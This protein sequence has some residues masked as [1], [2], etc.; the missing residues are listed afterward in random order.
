MSEC[1][2]ILGPYRSGTSLTA[3]VLE[4]L[5]VDFGPREERIATNPYNPGGYLERGDLNAINRKLIASTGRTLGS[6]GDPECLTRLADRS[7]L[8]G[9]T[10]PWPGHATIWGLKD[11]RF[12][13]T[14]K[15]WLDSGALSADSIRIVQVTRD[16]ESIVLS[17]LEHPS[18]QK[19]CGRD[20]D[21][22]R[23]MVQEYVDL[24]NWQV[25]MLGVPTLQVQYEELIQ[26]PRAEVTRLASWLGLNDPVRIRHAIRCVGKRSAQQRYYLRQSLTFPFR[27]VR[28]VYRWA[29][30]G[31]LSIQAR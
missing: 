5:G 16:L 31:S 14:L 3:Q 18:V 6:P 13:A 30:V 21:A 10:L 19:F 28:K 29:W 1:V 24:S 20:V 12:C 23:R 26:E 4:R 17:S 7:I 8:N 11:P 2:I 25:R 15:I 9:V 22:A 27:A